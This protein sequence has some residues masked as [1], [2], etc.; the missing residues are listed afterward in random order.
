MQ[1]TKLFIKINLLTIVVF[2]VLLGAKIKSCYH[3]SHMLLQQ[4][5]PRVDT[6]E[7]SCAYKRGDIYKNDYSN[8]LLK[9]KTCKNLKQVSV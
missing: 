3:V 1:F 4:S 6:L 2:N 5:Q 7:K 9:T 8:T